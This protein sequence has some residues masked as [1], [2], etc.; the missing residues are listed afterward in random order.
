MVI[1]TVIQ[2]LLFSG[3]CYLL[4]NLYA[5][6]ISDR[7]IFAPRESS[8]RHLPKEVRI[9]VADGAEINAVYLEHPD[10]VCTI[11]FSHGNAEDLGN[12][13][14]FMTQFHEKGCSVLMYDYRGYG[15]SDG[16]PS[17]AGA[18][19]DAMA[20][21]RW[22]VEEKRIDPA[23]IVSHGRSLGGAVA[24][25]LAANA[26]VGGVITEISFTSAFRVK[27]RWKLLLT[28]KFDSLRSIRNINCPLLVIHGTEDAIIP[29][30]HARKVFDAAADPKRHLW[31]EGGDHYDYVF[32][33]EAAYF[34]AIERF[35][36][37]LVKGE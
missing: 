30:W 6:A 11:L 31:I 36:D 18:K 13:V 14:P 12:V 21:Y 4:L 15:T 26:Q 37:E 35:I 22:L 8:Y 7:L 25:W 17:T 24:V 16:Y 10:P 32:I 34:D 28:D 29:F 3:A 9:T 2:V 20:A 1:R 19:K 5:A 27:T 23:T 33:D